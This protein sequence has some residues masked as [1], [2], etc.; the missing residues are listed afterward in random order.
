M[1]LALI[2]CWRGGEVVIQNNASLWWKEIVRLED[3]GGQRWFTSELRRRVGNGLNTSFWKVKWCG[4]MPFKLKYPRL[5]S[6][7]S[8]KEASIGDLVSNGECSLLWRRTLF[9]WEDQL[10]VELLVELE[11][12]TW[13]DKEDR[14]RWE[15]EDIGIFTVKSAYS[16]LER[17]FLMDDLRREEERMVFSNLWKSPA[18]SKAIAFSW[19]LFL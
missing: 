5:F 10:V 16:K 3:F 2:V 1:A 13:S 12:T 6:L 15:L 8:Q 19:K 4:D 11:G 7:S 9:V 14:W 17:L 18:P